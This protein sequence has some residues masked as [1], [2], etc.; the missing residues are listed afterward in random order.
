GSE[1]IH[2]SSVM[3]ENMADGWFSCSLTEAGIL[4]CGM[5]CFCASGQ[6]DRRNSCSGADKSRHTTG[7]IQAAGREH[8]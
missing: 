4:A 5:A 7:K 8:A 3:R 1:F 2:L 6:S